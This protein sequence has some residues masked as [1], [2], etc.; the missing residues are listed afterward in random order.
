MPKKIKSREVE[1]VVEEKSKI[2]IFCESFEKVNTQVSYRSTLNQIKGLDTLKQEKLWN[3]VES[4]GKSTDEKR[5]IQYIIKGYLKHHKL[6]FDLFE[7]NLKKVEVNGKYIH[8]CDI[9]VEEPEI[10][11]KKVTTVPSLSQ[12]DQIK[13]KV[14][15]IENLEHR[16]LFHLLTNYPVLRNDLANVKIKNYSEKEARVNFKKKHDCIS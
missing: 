10:K 6:P 9:E 13:E 16:L 2:E 15:K 8:T 11:L 4:N 1:Q 3:L 12:L 7:K 14:K 5:R